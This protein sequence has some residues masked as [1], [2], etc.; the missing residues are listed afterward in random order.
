MW[1]FAC[2]LSLIRWVLGSGKCLL[3]GVWSN[4]AYGLGRRL[5]DFCASKKR[6]FYGLGLGNLGGSFHGNL[7]MVFLVLSLVKTIKKWKFS[8]PISKSVC[9]F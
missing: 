3:R 1:A 4:F 5:I 8:L 6:G 2:E 9:L 7:L